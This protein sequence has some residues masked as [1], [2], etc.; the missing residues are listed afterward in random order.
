MVQRQRLERIG[1]VRLDAHTSICHQAAEFKKSVASSIY[2]NTTLS[3]GRQRLNRAVGP[4]LLEEMAGLFSLAC[5]TR[6]G[7]GDYSRL[8]WT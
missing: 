4:Y 3:S 7:L 5:N 6:D 2:A 1:S 8:G